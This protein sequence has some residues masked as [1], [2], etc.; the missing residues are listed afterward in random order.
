M[1]IVG[2][3]LTFQG[4][5]LT[6]MQSFMNG[7]APKPD[8]D[9]PMFGVPASVYVDNGKDYLSADFEALLND[10]GVDKTHAIPYRGSSKPIERF[11][12][13]FEGQ[14]ISK[15]PGYCGRNPENRPDDIKP[16]LTMADLERIIY[17]YIKDKYHKEFRR[18]LKKSCLERHCEFSKVAK[19]T[20]PPEVLEVVAASR[21]PRKVTTQGIQYDNILYQ[22]EALFEFIGQSVEIR[23][24]YKNK[25][26]IICFFRGEY[27]CHAKDRELMG[28]HIT[29]EDYRA[30]AREKK[31]QK[32][33][34]EDYIALVDKGAIIEDVRDEAIK[35][36]SDPVIVPGFVTVPMHLKKE[37][38]AV[39]AKHEE[40]RAPQVKK[41]NI[42][43]F[44]A[45]K[46]AAEAKAANS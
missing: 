30:I 10:M 41:N 31:N 21:V 40:D 4:N 24:V 39:K 6:I 2:Y 43:R 28:Y 46:E 9:Y 22:H 27:I 14:C 11:F 8:K 44:V 3:S 26:E 33:Q 25:G 42:Y 18:P 34:I 1:S 32:K 16:L 20:A 36:A 45:D 12:R 5:S 23:P 17:S 38:K 37:R 35:R 15:L 13:T 19:V 7:V 29:E